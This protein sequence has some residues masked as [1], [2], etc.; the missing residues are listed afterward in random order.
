[1]KKKPPVQN[2]GYFGGL[3]GKD[4]D[5]DGV[6]VADVMDYYFPEWRHITSDIITLAEGMTDDGIVFIVSITVNRTGI[7]RVEVD[8]TSGFSEVKHFGLGDKKI[9]LLNSKRHNDVY[10]MKLTDKRFLMMI[11]DLERTNKLN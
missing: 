11:E 8:A 10:D 3:K 9:A 7:S 6:N 4:F 5:W 2:S 1:M